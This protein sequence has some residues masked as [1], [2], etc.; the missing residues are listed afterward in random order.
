MTNK[1]TTVTEEVTDTVTTF[2][3][4]EN[5]TLITTET[6]SQQELT[7]NVT[8]AMNKEWNDDLSY[9]NSQEYIQLA[10][11]VEKTVNKPVFSS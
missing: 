4:E 5:M 10:Y 8:F 3:P 6:V 7:Y 2:L 9:S 1:Y 11:D